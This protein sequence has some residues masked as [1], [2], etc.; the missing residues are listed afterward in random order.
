[1]LTITEESDIQTKESV[2][3][4]HLQNVWDIV[5]NLH[6]IKEETEER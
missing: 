6:L 2:D 4:N 1:M 3:Q 5:I